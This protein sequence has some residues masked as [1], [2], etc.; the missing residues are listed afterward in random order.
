[1]EEKNICQ[2]RIDELE[3]PGKNE[4]NKDRYKMPRSTLILQVPLV[5][6][7]CDKRSKYMT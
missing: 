4:S 5:F 1:M 7:Y 6:V 2:D 3:H